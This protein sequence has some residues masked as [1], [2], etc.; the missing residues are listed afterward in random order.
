MIGKAT[1][2]TAGTHYTEGRWQ[3][4]AESGRREEKLLF[5]FWFSFSLFGPFQRDVFT[6]YLHSHRNIKNKELKKSYCKNE[7]GSLKSKKTGITGDRYKNAGRFKK[8]V[9]R[10][11]RPQGFVD[12]HLVFFEPL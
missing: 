12:I 6:C 5:I 7:S 11:N 1:L 3:S 10:N 2:Q 9:I 4:R 8:P